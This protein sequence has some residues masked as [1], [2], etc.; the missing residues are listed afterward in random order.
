LLGELPLSDKSEPAEKWSVEKVS[1]ANRIIQMTGRGYSATAPHCCP[2]LHID[3]A[4]RW[5]GKQFISTRFKTT[6]LPT[7]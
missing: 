1:I 7:S 3:A 5:D 4:Y 2:D 6:P